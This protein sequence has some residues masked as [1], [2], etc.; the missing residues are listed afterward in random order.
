M[1]VT[2]MSKIVVPIGD[3]QDMWKLAVDDYGGGPSTHC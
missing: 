1:I 3:L 2:E